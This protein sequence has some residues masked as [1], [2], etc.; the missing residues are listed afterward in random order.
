[1]GVGGT[2][3][4]L[5]KIYV[6]SRTAVESREKH[7]SYLMTV[8]ILG[9]ALGPALS[10]LYT[11]IPPDWPINQYTMP[12]WTIVVAS[13]INILLVMMLLN[14]NLSGPHVEQDPLRTQ[15]TSGS[16]PKSD[17]DLRTAWLC[18]FVNFFVT[19][20]SSFSVMIPLLLQSYTTSN[21]QI[22]N[23]Y[24]LIASA[25]TSIL[26][27][28]TSHCCWHFAEERRLLVI[29]LALL[30]VGLSWFSVAPGENFSLKP[31]C[32]ASNSAVTDDTPHERNINVWFIAISSVLTA[33][34]FSLFKMVNVSLLSRQIGRAHV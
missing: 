28:S 15:E 29:S 1:M 8:K 25:F 17:L 30:L 31:S 4:E 13:V 22:V 14:D 23:S 24:I 2:K 33:S 32:N 20:S 16:T 12:C 10:A 19:S 9:M 5:I 3:K 27:M 6:T 34:L 21:L 26:L 18:V 7:L 11:D